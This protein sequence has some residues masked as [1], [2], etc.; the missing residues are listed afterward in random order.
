LNAKIKRRFGLTIVL[1]FFVF[2]VL[3]S[4]FILSGIVAVTLHFIG[5]V[6]F[7]FM[8]TSNDTHTGFPFGGLVILLGICV[9]LGT[10]LTAFLS[11]TAL[12]PIR[13]V[14][15]ATQRIAEGDFN[16][17]VEIKGIHELEE[18]AG[19]FNKMAMELSGIET[20]RSDFINNFSHEF[21]T[22]IVSIRG[23]AKLL[24]DGNITDEEKQEY[25]EIII[26]ESERLSELST[27]ILNLLKYE[28][29]EIITEK[30]P[31]RLDEQVR[32]AIAITEP[33]WSGKNISMNIGLDEVIFNGNEDLL[34]QVWLNLIDNAV[35]FSHQNGIIGVSL[36]DSSES[37]NFSIQDN[38]AGMTEKTMQ[39]VF[40][41]FFQGDKSHSNTG[42]GLGLAMVK[43]IADLCGGAVSVESDAGKGSVFNVVLPK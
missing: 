19:S 30:A 6:D 12:K 20:L 10:A 32:R 9:L 39:H 16:A 43:R 21:K 37:V 11:R 4:A 29:I 42:N 13:E 34:Q 33:K 8:Q 25:L 38:G 28:A 27:N 5:I 26:S 22:P 24:K 15:K 31:F 2:R 23:F 18:L 41:K 14:I 3:F 1:V 7:T 35:K 36:M 17:R 40:D